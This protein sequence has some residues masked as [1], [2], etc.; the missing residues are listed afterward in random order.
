MNELQIAHYYHAHSVPFRSISRLPEEEAFLLAKTMHEQRPCRAHKRF[1]PER[2]EWY[3]ARRQA[4]ESQLHEEFVA[5][6]GKPETRHPIYFALQGSAVIKNLHQNFDQASMIA[7]PVSRFDPDQRSF[8]FGDSVALH[9]HPARRG[10]FM[11]D[12]LHRLLAAHGGDVD[13]LLSSLEPIYEYI[14][15]QVWVEEIEVIY[16]G[17]PLCQI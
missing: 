1:Q 10:P 5:I 9:D 14:E 7:V 3:W 16:S 13:A 11:S 8:T 12:A 15:A 6:G 2:W 17:N 4:A